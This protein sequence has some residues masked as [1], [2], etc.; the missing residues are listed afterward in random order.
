[1]KTY[2]AVVLTRP[3]ALEMLLEEREHTGIERLV[4]GYTIETGR[5]DAASR[6]GLRLF[7]RTGREEGP[8]PGI[9]DDMVVG[10]DR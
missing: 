4:E 7:G 8:V 5:V 2:D 3:T 10:F 6:K 1:M 9:G